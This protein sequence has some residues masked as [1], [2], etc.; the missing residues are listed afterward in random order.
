MNGVDM[1]VR[2]E[3]LKNNALAI[4]L[5]IS[6]ILNTQQ[7]SS[8]YETEAFIQDYSRKRMTRFIRLNVRYRFGKM[9]PNLFKRKKKQDDQ[10]ETPEIEDKKPQGGRL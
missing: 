4:S 2:K 5:N 6:D 7:Y 10:E 9:D 3:M 1:G 8:H